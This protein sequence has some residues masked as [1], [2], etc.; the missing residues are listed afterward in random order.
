MIEFGKTLRE[1]REAK[2]FTISQIAETTHMMAT[3]VRNLEEEDFSKIVA[4]IYGRGFVKLY[5][6]AVGI[7]AKPLVD[8]FMAIYNGNRMP[9]IKERPIAAPE[10]V[11]PIQVQQPLPE[12]T[13]PEP[14]QRPSSPAPVQPPA[15]IPAPKP[16]DV[17]PPAPEPPPT[18]MDSLF[19]DVKIPEPHPI[20]QP[21]EPDLFD[22]VQSSGATIPPP[23]PSPSAP[24]PHKADRISRYA[25]PTSES[26]KRPSPSFSLP[27][28]NLPPNF[29][30]LMLLALV[31]AAIIALV[32]FG[33]RALYRATT[34]RPQAAEQTVER[35][36][37]PAT[38]PAKAD[39]PKPPE[40]AKNTAAKPVQPVSVP[41]GR[42]PQK[43]PSLFID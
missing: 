17:P 6:E 34:D 43:I 5:C 28:I 9:E 14:P 26:I 16:I 42:T 12:P 15:P 29:W 24:P 10:S 2:G 27:T 3:I 8:E 1:A 4:P 30:R 21:V 32:C 40:A 38:A 23:P 25:P 19:A 36:K 39:S 31:T 20:P 13:A 22:K 18:D 41:S 33:M 7:D 11:D 35:S 37:P